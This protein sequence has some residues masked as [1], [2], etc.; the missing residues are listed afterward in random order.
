MSVLDSYN[1]AHR[2]F[3]QNLA[4]NSMFSADQAMKVASIATEQVGLDGLANDSDLVAFVS[5][6]NAQLKDLQMKV[7][8]VKSQASK[9]TFYSLVNQVDDTA[10]ELATDC[11]KGA[12][13]LYNLLIDAVLIHDGSISMNEAILCGREVKAVKKTNS[14][15]DE[16]ITRWLAEGWLEWAATVGKAAHI[17]L[18]PRAML[19][20]DTYM[21]G[22]S[23]DELPQCPLCSRVSLVG[24]RCG[25]CAAKLCRPCIDILNTSKSP[26]C[27]GCKIPW[28][29]TA[30][31]DA[32]DDGDYVPAAAAAAQ[33]KAEAGPAA[34]FDGAAESESRSGT[35]SGRRS[36]RRSGRS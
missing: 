12:I 34:T 10:A 2:L 35:R 4:D 6:L 33:P 18:G 15:V 1:D 21:Q 23:E 27:P 24:Q 22:R 19:E 13:E 25:G 3:L 7:M 26:R 8:S 29:A 20:L 9:E 28:V 31:N 36:T 11:D 30:G 14:E 17:T 32:D 16:H 5:M